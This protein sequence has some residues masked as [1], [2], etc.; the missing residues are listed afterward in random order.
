MMMIRKSPY[1]PD[2]GVSKGGNGPL[3][4]HGSSAS[5]SNGFEADG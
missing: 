4:R 3:N 1:S 5:D 2:V